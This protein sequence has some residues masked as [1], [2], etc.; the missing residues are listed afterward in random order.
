MFRPVSIDQPVRPEMLRSRRFLGVFFLCCQSYELPPAG[1]GNDVYTE[2][3]HGVA[4]DVDYWKGIRQGFCSNV[5]IEA[6]SMHQTVL[7]CTTAFNFES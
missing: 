5:A 6:Y 7:F 1:P 3:V 2:D 4:K